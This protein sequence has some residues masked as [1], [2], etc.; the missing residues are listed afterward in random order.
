MRKNRKNASRIRNVSFKNLPRSLQ[1]VVLLCGG[2]VLATSFVWKNISQG[3]GVNGLVPVFNPSV[4]D[5]SSYAHIL[6]TRAVDGD[7]LV[8]EN[9][10]RVRLIGIDTP[11]VHESQKLF[12]D[13][14]R[15]HQDVA[16]IQA[17]GRKSWDV[18]KKLVEGKYVRLEFDVEK[19]DRY[20]RLLAY[21]YL[22][23]GRMLNAELVREGYAQV[24]TFVPNIKYVDLFVA[25]ERQARDKEKG[26][27]KEDAR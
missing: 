14:Q 19:Q 18:T 16:T 27:W 21:V 7:T 24:Y 9:K 26:L 3:S 17:M 15:T 12:R 8:L 6:V 20:G 11:E 25:L 1:L 13:S 5:S 22:P 4:A 2:L 10:E 23:D